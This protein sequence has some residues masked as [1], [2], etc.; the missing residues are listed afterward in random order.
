M[1]YERWTIVDACWL[2]ALIIF[3]L[4]AKNDGDFQA[5]AIAVIVI[6]LWSMNREKRKNDWFDQERHKM[7]VEALKSSLQEDIDD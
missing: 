4:W 1:P 7:E 3:P 2:L 5:G 6:V